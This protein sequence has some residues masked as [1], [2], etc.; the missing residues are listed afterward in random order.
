MTFLELIA[1]AA[2]VLTEGSIIE[3]LR[4]DPAVALDPHVLHAHLVYEAEGRGRL[5]ALYRQ[6]L[7]IGRAAGLP[8]I[9]GTP[10]WRANPERLAAAGTRRVEEVN[11]EGVWFVRSLQGEYGLYAEQV[12]IGG[13]MACRGDAYRPAEALPAADAAAFHAPQ[14][15][16]LAEG[17]AD[18]LLAATLPALSEAL[19]MARAMGECGLPYALSFVLRPDGGLLDGTPLEKAVEEIDNRTVPP[20]AF[21]LANCVHP[22]TFSAALRLAGQRAPGVRHRVIGLQGNTS[23]RPPESLDQLPV[24]D[25]MDPDGFAEAMAAVRR[26]F[27]TR[28]LGGCCGTDDRHIAALARRLVRGDHEPR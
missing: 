15:R 3:R 24:L 9:L 19:G 2:A 8:L 28:V 12:F 20:P 11:R 18:F 10:T 6:H 25:E 7:D 27:G 21:Y 1:Q 4:R 14:A 26:E 5:G 17:G 23:E 22:R 16:A 13:L